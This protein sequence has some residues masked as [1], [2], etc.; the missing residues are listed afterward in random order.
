MTKHESI[1]VVRARIAKEMGYTHMASITG[2]YRAT[3]YFHVVSINDVI[4]AGKWPAADNMRNGINHRHID[5]KITIR[6]C[7][8]IEYPRNA[9]IYRNRQ[10]HGGRW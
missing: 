6:R 5:W 3:Q 4:A 2:S 8:A 7:H 9:E 1:Y 10:W